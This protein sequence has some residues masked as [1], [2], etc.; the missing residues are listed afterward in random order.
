M[1]R[2]VA[3][4]ILLLAAVPAYPFGQNKIVYDKFDWKVYRSTHF[5][6]FFYES[7][8]SSLQKVASYAESA[9]ADISWGG[10]LRPVRS[11][12]LPR[13]RSARTLSGASRAAN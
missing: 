12:G 10:W 2:V 3:L 4:L 9:Y 6:I 1:K 11:A 5:T 7:E 13:G 8:R